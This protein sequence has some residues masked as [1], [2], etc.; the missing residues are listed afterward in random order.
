MRLFYRNVGALLLFCK[1]A[2]DE[3]FLTSV[4][5]A[6]AMLRAFCS[7]CSTGVR[8]VRA[9]SEPT[10][11]FRS[12]KAVRQ[13]ADASSIYDVL[14]S[15]P[16]SSSSSSSYDLHTQWRWHHSIYR[17]AEKVSQFQIIQKIILN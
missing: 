3:I 6:S 13:C 8:F 9:T 7:L 2:F 16:S 11:C 17:V 12:H 14:I 15:Q 5:A 1:Q 4:N 10:S